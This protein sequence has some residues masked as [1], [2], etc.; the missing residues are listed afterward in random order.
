MKVADPSV[1]ARLPERTCVHDLVLDEKNGIFVGNGRLEQRSGI[2]ERTRRDDTPAR[3]SD[4]ELL[5]RLTVRRTIAASTAHWRADHDRDADQ[6]V[7]HPPIFAD[8]IEHLV[9][10]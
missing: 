7:V 3:H 6:V 2:V 5:E 10:T 9:R 1:R 8:V 4:E